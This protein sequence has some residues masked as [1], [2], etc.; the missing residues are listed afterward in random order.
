M[1]S[2]DLLLPA[3]DA[4]DSRVMGDVRASMGDKGPSRRDRDANDEPDDALA[5]GPEGVAGE[6]VVEMDPRACIRVCVSA[7]ALA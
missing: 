7:L 4:S 6:P 1:C 2:S 3:T 5:L